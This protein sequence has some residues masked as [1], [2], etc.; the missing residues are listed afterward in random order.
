[1][2]A[3]SDTPAADAARRR[4]SLALIVLGAI[5]MLAGVLRLSSAT[6]GGR[7]RRF[8]ER[9]TYDQV[10]RAAHEAWPS[11]LLISLAGLAATIAGA[12]LR[13]PRG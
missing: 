4:W 10:K 3:A 8:E 12:R 9:R 2:D 13:A 11:S 6:V 7:V 5:A 1:M